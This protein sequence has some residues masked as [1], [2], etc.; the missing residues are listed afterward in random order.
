MAV[1][2]NIFC[3]YGPE[4]FLAEMEV[5]SVRADLGKKFGTLPEIESYSPDNS[6]AAGLVSGLCTS[7]LFGGARLVVL[8]GFEDEDLLELLE[9]RKD[10]PDSLA[11]VIMTDKLDKRARLFKVLSACAAVKEFKAFAEWETK[12]IIDWVIMT[13]GEKGKSIS[14]EDAA[15][16]NE[17]SGPS[18]RQLSSEIEKLSAYAHDRGRIDT[19]DI[20]ALAVSSELG[21]F[22]L[23]NAF[24]RRDLSGALRSLDSAFRSKQPA[25]ALVGRLASKLRPYIMIKALKSKKMSDAGIIKE[26]GMNPYYYERCLEGASK[27]SLEELV[28]AVDILASADMAVKLSSSSPRIALETAIVDIMGGN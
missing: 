25:H 15:L 17:I 27:Y 19:A 1:S 21:A 14:H 12:K 24:A 16:L 22:A 11:L 5:Q 7:S 6:S 4:D 13:A 10:F 20:N 8:E 18:L 2:G 28:R 3:F 23:E 26:L 9:H